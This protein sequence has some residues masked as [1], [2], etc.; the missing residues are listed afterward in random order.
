MAGEP[1]ISASLSTIVSNSPTTHRFTPA[2]LF[3]KAVMIE[4][5]WPVIAFGC[6]P[7]EEETLR[8][9]IPEENAPK[10]AAKPCF[11][12]R[13]I[14]VGFRTVPFGLPLTPTS[15]LAK[16]EESGRN[17]GQLSSSTRSQQSRGQC[18]STSTP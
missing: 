1:K 8:A 9:L 18:A 7:K 15:R 16:L 11:S 2:S 12:N 5:W 17:R 3:P 14:Y 6:H 13:Q 4:F 10:N